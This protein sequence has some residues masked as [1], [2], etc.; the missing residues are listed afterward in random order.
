MPRYQATVASRRPA[1]DTFGYLATFSNAAEWDPGV[2][3]AGQLDPGPVRP[4]TRF[5]LIVPF[6]RR[7][8]AL[9]YEVVTLVPGRE[10]VL[11]A[12]S[13]LLRATDRIT[14]AADGD[15]AT[16]SYEAIV[17]L[18]G[19]LRLLDGLLRPGFRAVGDRAAAGLAQALSA[20]PVPRP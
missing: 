17:R 12:K 2:I 15:G 9:T 14:V 3:S 8:L 19:P 5:R 1:P 6:L 16:V 18:R 11:A 10:V 13:T 20:P 7:R 4:G